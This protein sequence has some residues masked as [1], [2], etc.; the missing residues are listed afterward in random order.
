[1]TQARLRRHATIEP[2]SEQHAAPHASLRLQRSHSRDA[3]P[4]AFRNPTST[5]SMNL[6]SYRGVRPQLDSAPNHFGDH[7]AIIGRVRLGP[8]P[9][10]PSRARSAPTGTTCVPDA[11]SCWGPARPFTSRT[12]CIRR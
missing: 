9:G 6:L 3:R 11:A 5:V 10:W 1:V 7:A 2:D 8:A 12:T 4:P